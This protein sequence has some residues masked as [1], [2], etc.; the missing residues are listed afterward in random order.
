MLSSG[1]GPS[2]CVPMTAIVQKRTGLEVGIAF[3]DVGELSQKAIEAERA[4]VRLFR[5]RRKLRWWNPIGFSLDF[6]R[7]FESVAKEYDVVHTNAEWLFTIWWAAFVAVKLRKKL[8]MMPHGSFE[9]ERLR[10][11]RW[12][13]L[14]V[15]WIDKWAVRHAASVWATAECEAA[16]VEAFVPGTRV[17]IFPIGVEVEK[18]SCSRQMG[19]T[20]LYFSRISPVKGLDML[21]EAWGL[22]VSRQSLVASGEGGGV[23]RESLVASGKR[24]K[25]LIVGPDDRGYTEEAKKMFAAKCEPGS[26]E[27]R[28][29]VY[30]EEKFRLLSSVDAFILPT[31]NENWGIAVAEAMA[32]GLPVICTKGAPWQCLEMA[33]AGWWTDIT[34]E[35]IECAIRKLIGLSRQE[36]LDM[37][38][39]GRAWVE[40]N[41]GWPKIGHE[42]RKS[43][44]RLCAGA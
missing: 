3:C 15:G 28:P 5:F 40:E 33:H 38:A 41:L 29:P 7:R 2:D 26:Y 8:V 25:L 44:E 21:A 6:M 27:F 9:P 22:V 30:G 11:S 1:G 39:N 20:I 16:G 19:K 42:M 34:A 35:G 36:R 43:Y 12:K 31:Y 4:G 14:L 32:S 24:W 37:G 23:S 13:K 17:E 18:Y 10:K